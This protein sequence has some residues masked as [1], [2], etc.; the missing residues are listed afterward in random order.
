LL[1]AFVAPIS[2]RVHVV[3]IVIRDD[4]RFDLAERLSGH[5]GRNSI[6][7]KEDGNVDQPRMTELRTAIARLAAISAEI[8]R[9]LAEE[10][11]SDEWETNDRR[12]LSFWHAGE[13]DGCGVRAQELYQQFGVPPAKV[14]AYREQLD[15]VWRLILP[16]AEFPFFKPQAPAAGGDWSFPVQSI[17]A[18]SRMSVPNRTE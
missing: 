13:R 2:R 10:L 8:H 3:S 1:I 15:A 12:S 18:A 4:G 9:P 17:D 11:D 6:Y 7:H 14:G 5:P 16:L